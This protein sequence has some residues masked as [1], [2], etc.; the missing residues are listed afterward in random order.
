MKS[1]WIHV[2]T[3]TAETAPKSNQKIIF[4]TNWIHDYSKAE[5]PPRHKKQVTSPLI[6]MMNTIYIKFVP[7]YLSIRYLATTKTMNMKMTNNTISLTP[8]LFLFMFNL[9]LPTMSGAHEHKKTTEHNWIPIRHNLWH[10]THIS[11][12][13]YQSIAKLELTSNHSLQ[14]QNTNYLRDRT[15]PFTYSLFCFMFKL[16]GDHK[17]TSDH[18]WTPTTQSPLLSTYPNRSGWS[19]QRHQSTVNQHYLGAPPDVMH[20]K[21]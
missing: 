6:E 16:S 19:N 2:Y 7:E 21:K 11:I 10:N 4:K 1:Y 12:E 20:K 5:I 18:D 13:K 17:E 15:W 3:T 14:K 8:L 9:N